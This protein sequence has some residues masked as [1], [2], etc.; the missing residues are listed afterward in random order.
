MR[1]MEELCSVPRGLCAGFPPSCLLA[2]GF[3]WRIVSSWDIAGIWSPGLAD[4]QTAGWLWTWFLFQRGSSFSK[5][6]QSEDGGVGW[7][8]VSRMA[9]PSIFQC[10][11]KVVLSALTASLPY[12]PCSQYA[13]RSCAYSLYM[14]LALGLQLFSISTFLSKPVLFSVL[15]HWDFL[16]HLWLPKFNSKMTP[17]HCVTGYAVPSPIIHLKQINKSQS[18]QVCASLEG[19]FILVR[20]VMVILAV[21]LTVLKDVKDWWSA[22]LSM[23]RGCCQGKL[24]CEWLKKNSVMN[25]PPS[26]T[27]PRSSLKLCYVSVPW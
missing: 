27:K 2:S 24:T 20:A 14:W 4:M 23:C 18:E 1:L 16:P 22:L 11:G 9:R 7:E 3:S 6:K 5:Q 19:S 10:S 13:Q 12:P 21:D 25:P 17:D 8:R 26:H 15:F